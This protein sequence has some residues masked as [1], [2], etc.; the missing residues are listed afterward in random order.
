MAAARPS[1]LTQ[2]YSAG[3]MATRAN[4]ARTGRTNSF[5]VRQEDNMNPRN[6]SINIALG[7]T[8]TYRVN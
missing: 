8:T 2:D 7:V 5:T 1:A 3:A 6:R 4:M